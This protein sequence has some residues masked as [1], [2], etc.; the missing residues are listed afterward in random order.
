MSERERE[1]GREREK[2]GEGERERERE[3][4]DPEWL[5]S[6]KTRCLLYT[7]TVM[8]LEINRAWLL[9][10]N[11]GLRIGG[12]PHSTLDSILAS[13]P[14]VPGLIPGIPEIFDVAKVNR[15]R[16]CLEQWTAEA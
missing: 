4:M 13:H 15:Q 12:G 1:R 14:A 9:A 3:R 11:V 6:A 10:A 7:Y 8:T 2:E 16:C 5:K